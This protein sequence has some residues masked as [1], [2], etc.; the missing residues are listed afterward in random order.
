MNG[1]PYT[2]N[3]IGSTGL[4]PIQDYINSNISNT[5]NYVLNT[6]NILE[7]N[8]DNTSN[9]LQTQ[10]TATSNLI[11]KDNDL[12]TIV[13][14]SAQNPSYP[15]SGNP[16]EMRFLNV[17]NEYLTKII[18]T[19]E[20]FVY[21][22]LTPLPAG[23]SAGWW[24]VEG[25]IAFAITETQGLRLDV[26]NLQVLTGTIANDVIAAQTT[27][28]SAFTLATTANATAGTALAQGIVNAGQISTIND[29]LPTLVSSTQ[30][31]TTLENYLLKSGGE[32]TGT[33]TINGSSY[34]TTIYE[35]GTLL[36]NKYLTP[37]TVLNV[38][39]VNKKNGFLCSVNNPIY[40]NG[41][42]ELFYKYDIYLPSYTITQNLPYTNDPYRIFEINVF[43]AT[44]YFNTIINDLPDIINYK[45][46]MSNKANAGSPFG[47]AGINLCATGFPINYKL[48]K[49]MANNIFLMRNNTN[50]FNYISII[51]RQIADVRV[52][53]TDLL[54]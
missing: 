17:N 24:S 2:T 5:S 23:Y 30:L 1:N 33:L 51:T 19:G 53:I 20:L 32:I 31:T 36:I 15:I 52:I 34:S 26:T 29:T 45:I 40:P 49:I 39:S 54:N 8:I 25:K 44:C 6:S 10:I 9:I 47:D 42:N 16:V 21:H 11:Y 37:S 4:Y 12:N 22:P 13:R 14:I 27:A 3:F 28:T 41:G 38:P 35:N 46:Y 48:D 18:Q 50:N 7:L 43:I